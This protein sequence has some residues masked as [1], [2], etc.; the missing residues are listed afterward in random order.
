MLRPM[1]VL[2]S[3]VPKVEVKDSAVDA[4]C[5]GAN[6]AMPGIVTLDQDIRKGG[7]V[8]VMTLSG[9]GVALGHAL[10]DAEE[11]MKR[12]EGF[13]IDVSRVFMAPGTYE[14]GWTSSDK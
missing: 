9:E 8:A 3:Q 2:L 4:V 7:L 10:M 5:H 12:S 11:I 13:A 1:E 6:V 14:K